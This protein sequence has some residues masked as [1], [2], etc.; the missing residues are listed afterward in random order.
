MGAIK[1]LVVLFLASFVACQSPSAEA[2]MTD[3]SGQKFF[4]EKIDAAGIQDIE[5]VLLALQSQ[6]S[7][8]VKIKATVEEVCQSKGCWMNV[9]TAG[10]TAG[11]PL[12]VQFKDYGF[13]MPKDCAGQEVVL[14]G[15]AYKAITPVEELRHFAEDAGK[16]KAEIEAITEPIEEKKFMASGVI[17]LPSTKQGS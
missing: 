7:V 13:F 9:K 1:Y 17:L 10:N 11:E 4:G 12:F 14:E 5:E 6:D 3:A 8:K 2:T 16:S 15:I